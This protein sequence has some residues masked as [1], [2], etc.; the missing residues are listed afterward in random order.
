MLTPQE[1]RALLEAVR[2]DQNRAFYFVL[3]TTGLRRGE[4]L[5]LQWSD[6]ELEGPSGGVL[7][8]RHQLQWP[9]GVATLVPVKT[10]KGVRTIPLPRMTVEALLERRSLQ[11]SEKSVIGGSQ[12]RAGDLVFNSADGAPFHRNTMMKQFQRHLRAARLTQLRLHDLRHTYGSLLM[13]Q[14]VPLKTISDLMGHASIEVTADVYLHSLDVHVRDTARMVE[15]ALGAPAS[16]TA[17]TGRCPAC[18]QPLNAA[19]SNIVV[20][21]PS[22]EPHAAAPKA[23]YLTTAGTT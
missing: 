18:G 3:L 5:G 17:G 15:N 20:D 7:H 8:V 16:V 2:G 1:G 13:S 23:R 12:W 4:A 22:P 6:L 9:K 10:R 21:P 11:M 14:G 19:G